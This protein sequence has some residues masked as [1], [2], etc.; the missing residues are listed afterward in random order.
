MGISLPRGRGRFFAKGRQLAAGT[1]NCP[2]SGHGFHQVR[3]RPATSGKNWATSARNSSRSVR[4]KIG[5]PREATGFCFCTRNGVLSPAEESLQSPPKGTPPQTRRGP[6]QKTSKVPL[7]INTP[8]AANPSTARE[9]NSAAPAIRY[10]IPAS[11]HAS[12]PP[13]ALIGAVST[14]A[15]RKLQA[16]KFP[17]T[18]GSSSSP[19]SPPWGTKSR[20]PEGLSH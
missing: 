16:G 2:S 4:F 8:L 15:H 17:G 18:S 7:V 13:P 6:D 10:N 11:H 9:I 14:G 5:R 1:G 12:E 3:Q 20:K 19:P